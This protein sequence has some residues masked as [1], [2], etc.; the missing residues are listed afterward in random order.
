M[1]FVGKFLSACNRSLTASLDG[2]SSFLLLRVADDSLS[3][4]CIVLTNSAF[5]LVKFRQARVHSNARATPMLDNVL[6]REWTRPAQSSTG[7]VGPVNKA[8]RSRMR[9]FRY[10]CRRTKALNAGPRG[11]QLVERSILFMFSHVW[12]AKNL[13]YNSSEGKIGELGPP[14]EDAGRTV[15]VV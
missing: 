10:G 5:A 6:P 11:A 1:N 15:V 14:F 2:N 3:I 12:M 13:T 7:I 4:F 9:Y 8:Q